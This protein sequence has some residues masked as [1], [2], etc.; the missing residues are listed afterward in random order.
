M[1]TKSTKPGTSLINFPYSSN[2]QKYF[3]GCVKVFAWIIY[4]FSR[5][6]SLPR[7]FFLR[8]KNGLTL[9]T[10]SCN[11]ESQVTLREKIPLER[12]TYNM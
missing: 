11:W 1:V 3:C 8:G 2:W 6:G 4:F 7:L 12:T 9:D 5:F 10:G